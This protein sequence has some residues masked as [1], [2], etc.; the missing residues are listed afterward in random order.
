MRLVSFAAALLGALASF[1]VSAQDDSMMMTTDDDDLT[2][3]LSTT[4]NM[5]QTVNYTDPYDGSDMM[6]YSMVPA[7]NKDKDKRPIVVI[8]PDWSGV[9]EYEQTR[10][11]MLAD[12][13]YIAFA[14]SIYDVN[15]Q[16]PESFDDRIS[17]TGLY[18]GNL[19]LYNARIA[20]AIEQASMIPGA[21]PSKGVA[22]IGYCFGGSGALNYAL[23]G[24]TGA[25]AAVAFHGGLSNVA[26]DFNKTV[27][28]QVLIVSGGE[29]GQDST[30]DIKLMETALNNGGN[31]W[32][33]QRYSDVE[34]GFTDIFS[35]RYNA[36]VEER[37]W[38][39]TIKFLQETFQEIGLAPSIPKELTGEAFAYS[40]PADGSDLNGY[41]AVPEGDGPFPAVVIIH[42]ADGI[43][44]YEETRAQ[45]LTEM[46][47]VGFAADIYGPMMAEVDMTNR[48]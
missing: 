42:N 34:H 43:N 38:P 25:D 21:D 28:S 12:Q 5:M 33:I 22:I 15:N 18:R 4:S 32:E 8:L 31:L 1:I 46:G 20:A 24:E 19:A 16:N 30:A 10:A 26:S 17:Q 13:G 11:A 35:S 9:D 44:E 40:D 41:V 7:D 45:M 36:Y 14:A 29:D 48:T 47:F 23:S 39:S 37:S 6:G 2:T 27:A 3:L